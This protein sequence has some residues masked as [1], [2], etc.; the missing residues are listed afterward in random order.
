[1]KNV[2]KT[3]RNFFNTHSIKP[4]SNKSYRKQFSSN[5]FWNCYANTNNGTSPSGHAATRTKSP[6]QMSFK[7]T[8]IQ[9]T[10][11]ILACDKLSTATRMEHTALAGRDDGH[12][13]NWQAHTPTS[14][15]WTLT[16][17]VRCLGI[18]KTFPHGFHIHRHSH[19]AQPRHNSQHDCML[20]VFFI[21]LPVQLLKSLLN[22]YNPPFV[23]L[24]LDLV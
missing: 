23:Q 16:C 20:C 14:Q 15:C 2:W 4:I 13:S 21:F 22:L 6:F 12:M 19:K 1:M 24:R 5:L 18:M 17:D 7:L 10:M 8:A 9:M 11:P 3:W